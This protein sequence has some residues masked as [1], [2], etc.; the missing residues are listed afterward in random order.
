VHLAIVMP[1]YNEV[2]WV[3]RAV[4]RVLQTPPPATPD[5]MPCS[6]TLILVDDGSTDGTGAVVQQLA[7][8]GVISLRHG[9]NLGKGAALRTGFARAL[10]LGAD[11]VLVHDADLEYD[12]RDHARVLEPILDGRADAVI[13]SR[14]IGPTHRVLYFWHYVANRLISTLC[15]MVTNLNLSDVECCIKAFSAQALRAMTLTEDR[16]EI[17]VE[18][19]AKV[20]QARLTDREESSPRRA[21]IYEV[22]VT[23]SGRTYEE[24]KKI[25]WQDGLRAIW[26]VFKHGIG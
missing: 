18:M 24:G 10:E 13:G 16:F 19:V 5:G 21:R 22:A 7:R 15:G 11:V 8:T 14:F 2:R 4:E 1:V 17:E 9:I 26:A 25:R 23:Y 20:A 3:G 6:R 12:P